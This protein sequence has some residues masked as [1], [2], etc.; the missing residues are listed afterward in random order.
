MSADST[1]QQVTVDPNWADS[2]RALPEYTYT[3]SGPSLFEIFMR[4]VNRMI[5][6]IIDGKAD[7]VVDFVGYIVII[8]LIVAIVIIFLRRGQSPLQT[9]RRGHVRADDEELGEAEDIDRLI[10]T[11]VHEGRYREAVRYLYL[12]S[13]ADLR[14]ARIIEWQVDKTDS[15]YV[16]DVRGRWEHAET[17]AAAVRHFQYYWY[18]EHTVD[19]AAFATVREQFDALRRLS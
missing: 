4:W 10:G 19:E 12:R 7:S 8:G 16:R 1:I 3:E 5:A 13:L 15:D 11:A 9:T 6:E 2:V 14:D 18:G 17:F